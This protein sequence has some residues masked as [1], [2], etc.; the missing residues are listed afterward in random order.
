MKQGIWTLP[1]YFG[2]LLILVPLYCAV[3]GCKK[4]EPDDPSYYS[5]KNFKVR[6]DKGKVGAQTN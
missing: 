3:S 1:A 2:V 5:G 4:Q 6:S